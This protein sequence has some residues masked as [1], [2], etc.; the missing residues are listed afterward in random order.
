LSTDRPVALVSGGSR[1]L[2]EALVR[3]LLAEGWTV[4]TFS[5]SASEAIEDLRAE[6]AAG[7]RFLWESLDAADRQGLHAYVLT[8]ARRFGRLDA[9]VNN[10]AVAAEGV[11]PLMGEE[12][13]HRMLAINLEAAIH[14]AR[15]CS[16]VM[17]Q[18]GDGTILNVSSVAGLR[19]NAGLAVYGATKAALDGFTRGLARELGPRGIRVN[20]VAPGY[21]ETEMT[22]AMTA[23]QLRQIVR[24]TPLGRLGTVD[25]VAELVLFLLSPGARFITGQTLVVDGGLTC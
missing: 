25:D 6:D 24:R 21:L 9:L 2:G 7:D 20:S 23:E 10:A 3:R 16:R 11:L 14:L 15:L 22:G 18:R 19:G 13:I 17:L 1:G 12:E 4:A 8:L 5:R